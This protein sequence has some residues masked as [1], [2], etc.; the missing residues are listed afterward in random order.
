MQD[1]AWKNWIY[2]NILYESDRLTIQ[3]E[4]HLKF[5]LPTFLNT[6]FQFVT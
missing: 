6:V 2:H 1:L 4:S 3:I 5:R